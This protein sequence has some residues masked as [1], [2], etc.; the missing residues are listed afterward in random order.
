M[1]AD[2]R[3]AREIQGRDFIV[4]AEYSPRTGTSASAIEGSA[5]FF[6]NVSAV[7]VSDNHYGIETSGLAV[8]AILARLGVEPVYQMTTRDRNRIALQSDLLGAAL[9]G[10]KN[11]LCISGYHQSLIGCADSAN[12]YD[13]DSIQLLAVA[14]KMNEEHT[15]LDGTKI[16]GPFDMLTGAAANHY[17]KPTELNILRMSKKIAAGAG[18]IQTS[19]VF[20][21]EAFRR[22]FEAARQKG[23]AGRAAILA[24]ILP[25]TSA[26]EARQ[27]ARGHTDIIIPENVIKRLEAAGSPESQK[28]EGLAICIEQAG[29]LRKIEG[30]RGIHIISGGKESLVPDISSSIKS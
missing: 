11:V 10:I 6:K 21:A 17:V 3:L 29:E 20:D 22:W 26:G 27:L 7:N 18:F 2:S 16:E 30:L 5:R 28:Q 24:G 12:V 25:L 19:A 15:L 13:I 8:S 1:K 14:K 9:L 4:T 23:L